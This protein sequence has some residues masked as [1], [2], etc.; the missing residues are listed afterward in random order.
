MGTF[1]KSKQKIW[2]FG[3]K[4]RGHILKVKFSENKLQLMH[5]QVLKD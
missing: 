4:K 2:D 3:G 5:I 1:Q